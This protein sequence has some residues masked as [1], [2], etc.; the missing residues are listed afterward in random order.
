MEYETVGKASPESAAPLGPNY[1][2][3]IFRPES[4]NSSRKIKTRQESGFLPDL[5]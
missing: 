4:K 2:S 1:Y 3:L 5:Y